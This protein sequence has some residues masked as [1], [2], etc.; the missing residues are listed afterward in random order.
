MEIIFLFFLLYVILK[1]SKSFG[2]VIYFF[3]QSVSSL[4]LFISVVFFLDKLVLIFLLAKLG[5]FPFFYWV[6]VVSV[7]LGVLGNM[8]VLRFQKFSVFRLF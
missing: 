3:F 6:I 4:L 7:K 5:L 8:F 1:E 2:L